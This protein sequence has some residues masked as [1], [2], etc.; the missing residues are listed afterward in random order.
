MMPNVDG[1]AAFPTVTA[2]ARF[3]QASGQAYRRSHYYA[4]RV[5]TGAT[6]YFNDGE[7]NRGIAS[8]NMRQ[9]RN[10][11]NADSLIAYLEP[12]EV[13]RNARD[14]RIGPEH[15]EHVIHLIVGRP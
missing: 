9:A 14:Y 1:G 8:I 11:P 7:V 2:V 12:A 15:W 13:P 4:I 6:I 5:R 10:F 3:E